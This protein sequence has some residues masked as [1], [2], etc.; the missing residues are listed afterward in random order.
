MSGVG[1]G[2]WG[3]VFTFLLVLEDSEQYS[4]G[5]EKLII[6]MDG[7]RGVPPICGKFRKNNSFFLS[8]P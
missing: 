6:F 2:A 1:L 7:G 8:L 3:M 5:K 4:F